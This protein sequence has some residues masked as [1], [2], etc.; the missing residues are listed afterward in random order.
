M[1]IGTCI[2]TLLLSFAAGATTVMMERGPEAK[3]SVKR[4]DHLYDVYAL[5]APK[6][7]DYTPGRLSIY[8][9][10]EYPDYMHVPIQTD[11]LKD[12]R[13]HA[14]IAISPEMESQ[15]SIYVYDQQLQG[16]QLLLVFSGKLSGLR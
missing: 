16:D 7:K 8:L 9:R 13:Y 4:D 14:R 10:R 5:A 3:V 6:G 12:G 15:Y 1:K 11:R 2:V